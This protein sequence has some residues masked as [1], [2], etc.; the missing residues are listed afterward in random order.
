[1]SF[2]TVAIASADQTPLP[3]EGSNGTTEAATVAAAKRQETKKTGTRVCVTFHALPTTAAGEEALR[4]CAAGAA[5]SGNSTAVC[6]EALGEALQKLDLAGA[7][8][9]GKGLAAFVKAAGDAGQ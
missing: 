3:K 2:F 1:M 9:V 4:K 6:G 5:A 7:A 8:A